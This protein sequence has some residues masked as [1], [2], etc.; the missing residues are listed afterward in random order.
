MIRFL[1]LRFIF[2][3]IFA[4]LP[5]QSFA[6]R[7]D[8]AIRGTVVLP[9]G[10][11]N[12][13]PIVV[14]LRCGAQAVATTETDSGGNFEFHLMRPGFCVVHVSKEG[15]QEAEYSADI[16]E[17]SRYIPIYLVKAPSAG[18][19]KANA[20]P[21]TPVVDLRQLTVPKKALNEYERALRDFKSGKTGKA[22]ERLENALKIAPD[23]YEAH[24]ELGLHYMRSNQPAQGEAELVRAAELNPRV[25]DPLVALGLV[26]LQAG[27]FTQAI[28]VLD[29][30]VDLD[31]ASARAAYYLGAALYE[32]SDF[33]RAEKQLKHS[34]L[35]DPELHPVHLALVNL[36]MKDARLKDAFQELNAYLQAEP[37]GPQSKSAAQLR[38]RLRQQIQSD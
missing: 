11:Q 22:V 16:S 10:Y 20:L 25:A 18:S 3:P 8:A 34:L 12:G 36:Y 1:R 27:R 5:L 30:A 29:R 2:I 35:L 28:E 23:F 33:S 38:D 13:K 32:T 26:Y 19:G 6:Q 9:G 15:F 7:S 37:D 4:S 24:F 21:G 14:E 17:G 31:P